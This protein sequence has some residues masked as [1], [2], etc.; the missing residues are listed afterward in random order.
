[1]HFKNTDYGFEWGSLRV[2]R[3]ASDDR[4]GWGLLG[5]ITPRASVQIYSTKTGKVRV[6]IDGVETTK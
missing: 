3:S 5:V 1:M 2:Q 4:K 6:Y